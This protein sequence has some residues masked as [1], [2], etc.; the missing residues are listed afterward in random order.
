MGLIDSIFK[1]KNEE[2]IEFDENV[3]LEEF[4]YL[5]NRLRQEKM[6]KHP[7][8]FI[9]IGDFTYESALIMYW[10]EHHGSLKVG[11]YCSIANGV[12]IMLDGEHRHDWV[13]TYPFNSLLVNFDYI[14]GHPATKGDIIIGNDVWIASDTKIMSGVSI[15]DGCVVGANSLVTKSLPEFTI[16]GGVPAKIIKKR[17]PDQIIEELKR[18]KWWDWSDKDICKTIP[19]LQSNNFENII[20]YY[21]ENIQDT[22]KN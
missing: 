21:E 8:D 10:S 17:F 19:L 1:T 22:S 5:R 12:Q 3:I 7:E 15:G 6:A 4:I 13:T 2:E 9:E 20:K 11:K 16:C 14:K 18:I